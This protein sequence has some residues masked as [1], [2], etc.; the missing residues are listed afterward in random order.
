MKAAKLRK[1]DIE[2]ISTP[3]PLGGTIMSQST[4][5]IIG[6]ASLDN[7]QLL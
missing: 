6:S 5:P 3:K 7:N 1:N 2:Y 4:L